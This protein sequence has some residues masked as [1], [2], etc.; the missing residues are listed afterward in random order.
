MNENLMNKEATD[1]KP[2]RDTLSDICMKPSKDTGGDFK[3]LEDLLE[4]LNKGEQ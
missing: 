3:K 2:Y 4:R 1:F